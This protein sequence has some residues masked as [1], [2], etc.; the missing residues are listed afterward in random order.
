M[1]ITK[2][3]AARSKF[4]R[5]LATTPNHQQLTIY[6][7]MIISTVSTA[8]ISNQCLKLTW[9][10]PRLCWPVRNF[11]STRKCYSFT[12]CQL[13]SVQQKYNSSLNGESKLNRTAQRISNQT[14]L[15][16]NIQLEDIGLIEKKIIFRGNYTKWNQ[17]LGGEIYFFQFFFSENQ[18]FLC[19]C[20]K[21]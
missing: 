11:V 9:T 16:S 1:L 5:L 7:M 14:F 21:L 10:Y 17:I 19:D 12:K 2:V 20:I 6:C 18:F 15:T 8:R 4:Y 13:I 3:C